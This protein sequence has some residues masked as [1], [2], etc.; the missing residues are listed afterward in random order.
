MVRKRNKNRKKPTPEKLG[1][2]LSIEALTECARHAL[3]KGDFKEAIGHCKALI[4]NESQPENLAL[5]AE[6]YYG[7]A[8]ALSAKGMH[9]EAVLIWRNR[10]EF[11]ATPLV[12]PLFFRLLAAAGQVDEAL[13]LFNQQH[14]KLEQAQ[15]G[16]VRELFA[17]LAIAGFDQVLSELPAADPVVVDYPAAFAALQAYCDSDDETLQQQLKAIPFRSPYRDLRQLL[18]ALVSETPAQLIQ[19]ISKTSAFMSLAQAIEASLLA[20]KALLSNLNEQS[21]QSR[22]FILA[23][24]GWHSQQTFINE[25]TQLGSSPSAEAMI[26][27]TIR[28]RQSLGDAYVEQL[29]SRLAIHVPKISALLKCT[30]SKL[31]P[32]MLAVIEARRL[33]L[34]EVHPADI[35]DAW[36]HAVDLLKQRL[37]SEDE[38]A[39]K[40]TLALLF[41]HVLALEKKLGAPG[42]VLQESLQ[43]IIHYDPQDKSAY[44]QLIPALRSDK[45][46]KEAR[47]M[48]ELALRHF[49]DD[50]AIL[51]EAVE[52]ALAGNAFK[53]AAGIASQILAK[54]PINQRVRQALI[55]AHLAHARKQTGQ[56]KYALAEKELKA[57]NEWAKDQTD[58]AKVELV[59]G[60]L[61]F[62]QQ[63]Y[64]AAAEQFKSATEKL[65]G[66]LCGRFFLLLELNKQHCNSAPLLEQCKLDKSIKKIELDDLLALLKQF[67]GALKNEN[68]ERI[69]EAFEQLKISMKQCAKLRYTFDDGLQICENFNRYHCHELRQHF[70]RAALKHWRNASAYVYHELDAAAKLGDELSDKALNRL[71]RALMQ[72]EHNNDKGLEYK[73]ESLLDNELA[74]N[75]FDG[76]DDDAETPFGD[77]AMPSTDSLIDLM[78]ENLPPH[79]VKQLEQEMGKGG[80]RQHIKELIEAQGMEGTSPDFAPSQKPKKPKKKPPSNH[81]N[82]TELF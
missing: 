36:G 44:L 63:Y 3:Q 15:L 60:V 41:H 4:K 67:D 58:Q 77:I 76:F 39:T 14:S 46:L 73:L 29:T 20:D 6:A 48:V 43:K 24:K 59:H 1:A 38:S 80:L 33:E 31:N 21:P 78:L 57:A 32:L 30:K 19:R 22:S 50:M 56:K 40:L 23:L 49:P 52:T 72:A 61:A 62:E 55:D 74:F 64:E 66:P 54:D 8:C 2:S 42:Y 25:L 27:L 13:A 79:E 35:F 5:L 47:A 28:H 51:T 18:K 7:R 12:E 70:A 75:P 45:K 82:Q 68:P 11:C 81:P 17:S 37:G 69:N 71:R 65:G 16:A 10:T 53:K 34:R 26:R 9:K